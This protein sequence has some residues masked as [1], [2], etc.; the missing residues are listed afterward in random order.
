MPPIIDHLTPQVALQQHEGRTRRSVQQEVLTNFQR[1]ESLFK[2]NSVT[3]NN[4]FWNRV[5]ALKQHIV[6]EIHPYFWGVP[7][8]S[9]I[10][11]NARTFVTPLYGYEHLHQDL[12]GAYTTAAG[13]VY[14]NRMNA[15][16]GYVPAHKQKGNS[17]IRG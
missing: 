7:Q 1:Q 3:D 15:A 12:G 2:E 17:F 11:R 6:E 10:R 8:P 9:D 14:S 4:D 5:S 13:S 16:G